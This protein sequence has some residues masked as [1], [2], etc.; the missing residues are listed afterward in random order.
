MKKRGQIQGEFFRHFLIVFAVAFMVILGIFII[1]K[2][3]ST[4]C[5]TSMEVFKAQMKSSV[6]E[7]HGDLGSINQEE[8]NVPCG[9]DQIY[10]VDL[11]KDSTALTTSLTQYPLLK[12]AILTNTGENVFMIKDGK[13]V[14]SFFAGDIE[15]Q[16]PY[17]VCSETSNK[18][19]DLYMGGKG[20]STEVINTNCAFDCTFE[21]IE[22]D[23]ALA[24]ELIQDAIDFGCEGCPQGSI[25]DE[26]E[27]FRNTNVKI[28]RRCNCGRIPGTTVVEIMIKPEGDV[29]HFKLIEKIPKGYVDNLEDYLDSME[30]DY[31]YYKI[32]W[33]PLIMW[34]FSEITEDT[35]IRYTIDKE[36]FE[37][38]AD[39]FKTVG[40]A[41]TA[42][43]E[44]IPE[45]ELDIFREEVTGLEPLPEVFIPPG[46]TE[47]N[48]FPQPIW[49]Y[50]N[51]NDQT[52]NVK[53]SHTYQISVDPVDTWGDSAEYVV[54]PL[55]VSC[56]VRSEDLH[57]IC[58]SGDETYF[59]D[60]KVFNLRVIENPE[61][62]LKKQKVAATNEETP[63]KI[64]SSTSFT[65]TPYSCAVNVDE[66]TCDAAQGCEWCPPCNS[67]NKYSGYS[68]DRCVTEGTCIYG[69]GTDEDG[70]TYD[71]ECEGDCDDDI[72][73]NPFAYVINP[74]NT[75]YCDCDPAT[76][77]G[78]TTGIAEVCDGSEEDR[79]C[80][81]C[82]ARL[83]TNCMYKL[84]CRLEVKNGNLGGADTNC[85]EYSTGENTGAF[86]LGY[87]CYNEWETP[88]MENPTCAMWGQ[89]GTE[90]SRTSCSSN[91]RDFKIRYK[92][93]ARG[94]ECVDSFNDECDNY[95]DGKEISSCGFLGTDYE[96]VCYNAAETSCSGNPEYPID[97]IFLETVECCD[98]DNDCDNCDPTLHNICYSSE[99]MPKPCDLES[100]YWSTSSVK[101]DEQVTLTV[102]GNDGCYGKT[103]VF[104]V[105]EDDAP[106]VISPAPASATFTC[107]G[108]DC[109]A[110]TTWEAIYYDLGGNPE[111]FFVATVQ[112]EDEII[113]RGNGDGN[114]EILTVIPVYKKITCYEQGWSHCYGHSGSA[115]CVVTF[116]EGWYEITKAD[117]GDLGC[118]DEDRRTLCG[119]DIT[120][121]C[122]INP[123]CP[124][125][126]NPK[127]E[128]ETCVPTCTDG[129]LYD[130]CSTTDPGK[131]CENGNLVDR[132]SVCG[133][134]GLIQIEE[135]C[136]NNDDQITICHQ[137][138]QPSQQTMDI[139]ASAWGGHSGHGD[140]IGPCPVCPDGD[141][142]GHANHECGGDDC[143][144][145]DENINP[146]ATEVCNGIDDDC[147]PNT[148][149]GSGETA[150]DNSNQQGVC[151][152]SK[153]SCGTSGW[154][155]DYTGISG[156]STTE[157]CDNE[158]NNCD[159]QIDEGFNV[160]DACTEG[161]GA[162]VNTGEYV[163][164]GAG[165]AT[166]CNA[167]P[168]AQISS[169]DFTCDGV[170]DDCDGTDDE[171]YNSQQTDCGFGL[172]YAIGSTSCVNGVVVDSCTQGTPSTETCDNEDNN[173]DGQIDEGDLCGSGQICQGGSCVTQTCSDGTPY[174]E[175]STT[176]PQKC[177]DGE[178]VD[179]CEDCP[180]PNVDC[181]TDGSCC[182][183]NCPY[184]GAHGV[185]G[186]ECCAEWIP[187]Q[188][189]PGY[190][191][192]QPGYYNCC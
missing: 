130:E 56:K 99:C 95:Y 121:E 92:Y 75:P 46:V 20:D 134:S 8:I 53:R 165:T 190:P 7:L 49:K 29:E 163:C 126:T 30:G 57:I 51:A 5:T 83:D 77:G 175:C 123:T 166:E 174:G 168:G 111:Y 19:L 52:P 179:K 106:D 140:T 181:K 32:L 31:D 64:I 97:S 78:S 180:C 101:M 167:V 159:G 164:N 103:V 1:A 142:D 154:I 156:H 3:R 98:N 169:D 93:L 41:V 150:P 124:E 184:Y 107:I 14:D 138:G 132:A 170:D 4:S 109:T 122:S 139:T 131:R 10:F 120:T 70:D 44:G 43:S 110:T 153:Q 11:E 82:P 69:D 192:Y 33:D 60:S 116:G 117:H 115:Y 94:P 186:E 74:G 177:E 144:D 114:P 47:F 119:H 87:S 96:I 155:D 146:G 23:D 25:E 21:V 34:H 105:R 22:I 100:A 160:G 66:S 183:T 149:D 76:G 173:C 147:D 39:A 26:M 125:G 13:V 157:T 36:V 90:I 135:S 9:V 17:Y 28:A 189:N 148:A 73:T 158:D 58:D 88:C 129:T 136:Y 89:I 59:T 151:D 108:E 63:E 118:D 6:E 102:E 61:T 71:T 55:V 143:N 15:L 2:V 171:D 50:L 141:E 172:C 62:R 178:L 48:A 80:D 35:V 145:D 16:R 72:S 45:E 161:I 182:P 12:D 133:C 24:E 81:G 176:P 37:Y 65:V 40:L 104:Q 68:M 152:G 112:S 67:E 84:I 79:D 38:C 187:Q 128:E 185:G 113:S 18:D 42:E 54:N 137:P 188:G 191:G 86:G 91:A 85:Y 162:C 27:R 127:G